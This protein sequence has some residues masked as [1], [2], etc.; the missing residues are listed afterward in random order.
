[1]EEPI[2]GRAFRKVLLSSQT[3]VKLNRTVGK[4]RPTASGCPYRI[5]EAELS[6]ALNAVDADG[7]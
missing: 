1:V 7:W 6:A 4:R 5:R 2:L 3:T